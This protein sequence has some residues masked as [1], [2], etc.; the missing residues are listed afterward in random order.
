MEGFIAGFVIGGTMGI[1]LMAILQANHYEKMAETEE[2][3]KE[4]K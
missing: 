3:R 1:F 4:E 2:I